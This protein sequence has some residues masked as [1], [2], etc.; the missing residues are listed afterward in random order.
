M[1]DFL[2]TIFFGCLAL[3]SLTAAVAWLWRLLY[4]GATTQE[5][6]TYVRTEDGWR[7]A[8]HRYPPAGD[9]KT[10]PILLCHG[11]SSNRFTFDLP[12]GP[13]LA[14]FLQ[15][16][17]CDVWVVEL[18]GSGMSDR[19]G[20]FQ[21][22]VPYSWVFHDH[23][24][25]D[26]PAV[27]D[28]VLRQTQAPSL[29]WVGH[30]MGGMLVQAHLAKNPDAPIAS[31]VAVG[32]PVEFSRFSNQ[33]LKSLARFGWILR[34]IPIF[35]LTIFW[36]CLAPWIHLFPRSIVSLFHPPNIDSNLSGAV[37]ALASETITTSG[38]WAD[39][40]RFVTTRRFAP[41]EGED[42]ITGLASTPVPILAIAGSRDGMANPET[43]VAS[44]IISEPAGERKQLI[45]GTEAGCAQE[46]GHVD[47][48]VG[49]RVEREV[50]PHIMEWIRNH[51]P[52]A[53]P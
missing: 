52:L 11:L 47:L 12:G 46:Y 1:I 18:R 43:T 6:T 31:V 26:V 42:Y 48:V 49:D 21:A 35:P 15:S 34:L 51:D 25:R 20:L 5:M 13:S 39:F 17:G 9:P 44:N 3:V 45:L 28:H 4:G 22:N 19:P 10:L 2:L 41:P 23:L 32:S 16:M 37:V 33:I 50:F 38:V 36:K 24:R 27:V 8:V 29:H 14:R 40:S 53:V 7:L 30:S